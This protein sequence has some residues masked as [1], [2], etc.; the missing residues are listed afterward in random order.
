MTEKDQRE[1]MEVRISAFS[2]E[3]LPMHV[4]FYQPGVGRSIRNAR[5]VVWAHYDC[6]TEEGEYVSGRFRV[7]VRRDRPKGEVTDATLHIHL[8]PTPPSD[9]EFQDLIAQALKRCGLPKDTVFPARLT[10]EKHESRSGTPFLR[11]V[12]RG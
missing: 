11:P 9:A 1:R 6:V 7:L 2:P 10:V 3:Y 5:Q 12:R 8:R 4:E